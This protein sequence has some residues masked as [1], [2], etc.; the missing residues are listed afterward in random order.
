MPQQAESNSPKYEYYGMEPYPHQL[1]TVKFYLLNKRAYNFSAMGS[2][3]TASTIWACDML[4]YYGKIKKALIICPL[5]IMRTVWFEE[6]RKLAPDKDIQIVHGSRKDRLKALNTKADFYITNHDA[7]RSYEDALQAANFDVIVIDELTAYKHASSARS[8]AMVKLANARNVQCLWGLTGTPITTGPL[9][10]FGIGKVVN[11]GQLPT[12]YYTK[13]RG[14]TMIQRDMYNYDCKPGWQDT[15]FKALQPAI[16]FTLEECIDIPPITFETR[17]VALSP[18]QKKVYKE[19]V[20]DQIAEYKSGTIVAANAGTKALK[21]LQISGGTVIDEDGETHDLPIGP[22]YNELK[23]VIAESGNKLVVFCQFVAT[24]NRLQEMLEGDG[25]K[26]SKVYGDVPLKQRESIFAH[27]QE[28]DL[29][30][31]VAQVRTV[32]HGLTLIA[33]HYGCFYQPIMGAEA[34]LQAVQRIRRMGQ[35][36]HQVIVKL[37]AT[38][39]EKNLYKLLAGNEMDGKSI[40]DMYKSGDL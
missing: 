35:T 20:K 30:I 37:Q 23:M 10:A 19:M 12:R 38:Q 17:E 18:D 36:K 14:M 15:V 4:M 13:F 39:A 3:K 8:K 29:E 40:L 7:V 21:L 34:Y 26:C 5:S 11:F 6:I 9:D 24:V 33:S 25:F 27:F 28:G 31:L 1:E 22:R 32:S 16:K 2:G